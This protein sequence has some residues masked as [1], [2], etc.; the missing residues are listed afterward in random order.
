MWRYI[1]FDLDGTL[2]D[3]GEGIMKSVQYALLRAFDITVEDYT[4]LR[5]FVGPPLHDPFMR[6][7]G[8]TR[9]E[10]DEA[11]RLYRERYVPV[12]LYENRLYDGI[13]ELLERLK[14]LNVDTLIGLTAENEEAQRFYKAVP[15]SIMRD[16]GIWID[17]K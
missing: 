13:T 9:E 14:A 15:N 4:E 11:V 2:T 8:C 12:G 3:S 10:A 5:A 1:L 6:W 16:T 17:I 7:T